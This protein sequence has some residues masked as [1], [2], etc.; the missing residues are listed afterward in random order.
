MSLRPIA[1][2]ALSL[3]ASCLAARP[4]HAA[5]CAGD[6]TGLVPLT[7][8]GAGFYQGVQGGL[9]PAGSNHRPAAHNASGVAIAQGIVPLDTLGNPDPSNGRVVLISIGMSNATQEFSAFVPKAASAPGHNP[10]L[11]VV[12]CAVGGQSADRIR[13]PTAAYWDSVASR[14]RGRGSSPLQAQAVWLKEANA[15]PRGGFPAA[16]DTLTWNLG[17]VLRILHQKLPNVKLCYFTSR[18]YAGYATTTLN[19][20]PYAYESGFAVKRLIEGQI[21]GIDSL[22]FDSASGPVQAPWL[23]WGPYLWADGLEPRGDGL[24]WACADFAADGT[25][26]ATSA[27]Q[28]VSDSLLAFF[29]LDETTAPWFMMPSSAGVPPGTSAL[30]FTVSPNPAAGTLHL[31]FDTRPGV[32]WRIDVLDVAGRLV[33]EIARGAGQGGRE[34]LTWG[35]KNSTGSPLP[36]GIYSACFWSRGARSTRR[37]VV[38]DR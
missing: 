15:G 26:P 19:P 2:A 32:P 8:L 20:E 18:I 12:D 9:Y 38:L 14:L 23:A 13:T 17:T 28:L 1:L 6:S 34:M 27:R 37:V 31:A 5:N 35:L 4:A 24:T 29:T 25:H 30:F 21:S 10:R 7:D 33:C 36:P 16:T 22:E 3:A 11:L